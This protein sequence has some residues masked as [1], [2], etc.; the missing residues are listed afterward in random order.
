M[1]HDL[2]VKSILRC[3]AG[4]DPERLTLKYRAM[5]K[6]PLGFLR[7][8]NHLF[9]ETAPDSP[10]LRAA[11][12]VWSCGD[13]H[14]E[15]FG[16][17]K[18]D[19]R[20]VYFD[21]NDFDDSA[22]VPCTW[23]LLH[24]MTS[25]HAA[26]ES[27]GFDHDAASRLCTEFLTAYTS[28][29]REGKARWVERATAQGMVLKLLKGL[30][31]RKRCDFLDSRT[32]SRG[33]KRSIRTDT[34]KALPATREERKKIAAFMA[35]FAAQQPNPGFF[36]LLDAA[37]RIAG[38]GSLGTERYVLLVE[39]NGSPDENYLLDLKLASPSPLAR[40]FAALQPPWQSEAERVAWVQR[41][42]QAIAPALLQPVELEG[43][44]YVIKELQPSGDKVELDQW[45]G[46]IERLEDMMTTMGEITS[47][48]HLRGSGRRGA[49][50]ADALIAFG[51]DDTWPA[52]LATLARE[53]AAQ[54]RR[55]WEEFCAGYDGEV[56]EIRRTAVQ[57]G[58]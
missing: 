13:L 21:I 43:R 27:L 11:P 47:W 18:G 30:K 15:N 39:G 20:L 56:F 25:V 46:K 52:P 1:A 22:L 54:T 23:D 38:T 5:R 33:K 41:Q 58:S 2:T 50:V 44:S 12:A 29:L 37:R 42:M 34:G 7:G 8:T 45:N 57:Q 26:A 53:C 24:F 35:G 16:S 28:A 10:L 14:I 36:T 9:C 4:R 32:V 19:N 48:D 17:Y 49:A 6:S 51:E 31:R 55:Q 40:R 3:N